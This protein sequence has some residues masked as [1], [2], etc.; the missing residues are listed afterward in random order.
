M[1]RSIAILRYIRDR[2][3]DHTDPRDIIAGLIEHHD[4]KLRYPSY[5]TAIRCGGAYVEAASCSYLWTARILIDGLE[6][7]L[8]ANSSTAQGRP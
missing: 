5:R 3:A 1:T 7:K 2:Q 6:R 4:A 8:A